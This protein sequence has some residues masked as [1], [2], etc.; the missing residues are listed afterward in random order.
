MDSTVVSNDPAPNNASLGKAQ[1]SYCYKSPQQ[2]GQSE[3][4]E[5]CHLELPSPENL[6]KQVTCFS[7]TQGKR[8]GQLKGTVL[9]LL[10][11]N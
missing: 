11:E 9:S 3:T 2:K 7:S 10:K 8:E 6:S 5:G 4:Q 1:S